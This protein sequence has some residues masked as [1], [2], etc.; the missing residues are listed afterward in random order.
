VNIDESNKP[1]VLILVTCRKKE[2]LRAST[3]VFDTIRTG[4]PTSPIHAYI[5]HVPDNA[6]EREVLR[7]LGKADVTTVGFEPGTPWEDRDRHTTIHHRWI[8]DLLETR[9]TP[10]WICDTDVCFW[11]KVED[12]QLGA[13]YFPLFGR[14]TPEFFDKFTNCITRARLHTS[15][16][17]FNPERIEPGLAGYWKQFP[18]TPFNPRPNLIYPTFF[19]FRHDGRP[20]A[21][22]FYD[23]CAML[24]HAIG[25]YA[26]TTDVL[27]CYDHLHFGTIS[28]LVC[29][30]WA[31]NHFR[32]NHFAVFENP[33]LLK[34]AWR[35][36]EEFYRANAV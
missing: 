25:G 20:Y 13:S 7:A 31:E 36:Q 19:P 29:P 24:Y 26:F 17:Y 35:Q 12:F 27:N 1:P 15:L 4:F 5:N 21:N 23:T 32:E 34:G 3:L 28:D 18:E 2:L 30:Y 10:F 14:Y 6:C 11:D 8:S 22:F 16:L 9:K 33:Q